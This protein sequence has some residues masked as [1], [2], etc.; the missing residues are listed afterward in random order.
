MFN[1]G[2]HF[3]FGRYCFEAIGIIKEVNEDS[4]IAET[5]E[6]GIFN[7]RPKLTKVSHLPGIKIISKEEYDNY[8]KYKK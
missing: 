3:Y 5:I 7:A 1:I 4:V 8:L 2:D 6:L